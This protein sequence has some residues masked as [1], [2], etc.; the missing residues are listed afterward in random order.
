MSSRC[1]SPG[2]E[3]VPENA[4]KVDERRASA[5][6]RTRL[7]PDYFSVSGGGASAGVAWLPVRG[8]SP[9]ASGRRP[10]CVCVAH[11]GGLGLLDLAAPEGPEEHSLRPV[12][13]RLTRESQPASPGPRRS[14]SRTRPCPPGITVP[15]PGSPRPSASLWRPRGGGEP[16]AALAAPKRAASTPCPGCS[17]FPTRLMENSPSN[18]VTAMLRLVPFTLWSWICP[19]VP[20]GP[21]GALVP[22]APGSRGLD[23]GHFHA[24]SV[25]HR[26]TRLGFY[27]REF[28]SR[29]MSSW[30]RRGS[31]LGRVKKGGRC[32]LRRERKGLSLN[33]VSEEE[34]RSGV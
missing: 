26:C 32:G 7:P 25:A 10:G 19:Q 34:A 5:S 6:A 3:W 17:F 24:G 12:C 15:R 23:W 13:I 18:V 30:L 33:R 1:P 29:A 14:H 4:L 16:A 22:G 31:G 28:N 27:T 2:R 21:P 8:A 20:L 9:L 11:G